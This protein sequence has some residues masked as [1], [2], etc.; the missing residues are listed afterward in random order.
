MTLTKLI[1]KSNSL[2]SPFPKSVCPIIYF[3]SLDTVFLLLSLSLFLQHLLIERWNSTE[4]SQIFIFYFPS[5]H[6]GQTLRILSNLT[7]NPYTEFLF[8]ALNSKSSF[9]LSECSFLRIDCSYL[10]DA[11]SFLTSLS[12][13][14]L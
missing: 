6:F 3:E 14:L 8:S 5:E 10:L 2:L 11:A 13:L 12:S 9:L 1:R 4:S 7:F